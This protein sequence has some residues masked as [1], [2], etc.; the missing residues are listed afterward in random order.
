VEPF[1]VAQRLYVEFGDVAEQARNLHNLDAVYQDLDLPVPGWR[2]RPGDAQLREALGIFHDQ[3]D[4]YEEA[5]TLRWIAIAQRA[6]Q[7]ALSILSDLGDDLP[8]SSRS[9]PRTRAPA[10]DG[11]R[12]EPS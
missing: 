5:Y 6:W 10:A 9:R 12:R 3:H 8:R 11:I 4:R 1:E 2:H 7:R